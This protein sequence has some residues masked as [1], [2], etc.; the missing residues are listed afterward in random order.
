MILLVVIA[1][2][3][4]FFVTM[5]CVSVGFAWDESRRRKRFSQM[6]H[7]VEAG[8]AAPSKE[9]LRA[10]SAQSPARAWLLGLRPLK[11]LDRSLRQAG[12]DWSVER[13]IG[14]CAAG[15][16]AG[17]I[18]GYKVAL[19]SL[20]VLSLCLFCI[21]GTLTPVVLLR[22]RHGKNIKKFEEQFPEALD[23]LARCL[24]AGH[25]FNT[26]LEMLAAEAPDPLGSA[27]RRIANELQLGSPLDV[28]LNSLAE[29]VPLI[30]V[31]FFISAIMIQRETGGNLGEILNNLATL[32][33]SR[34][35]LRGQVKAMSAHGRITGLVLLLIPVVVLVILS[36]MSPDY[37]AGLTKDKT[38]RLLLIGAGCG[39]VLAYFCIRKIVNIKI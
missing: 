21:A 1:F 16:I 18:I 28:A 13:F 35:R 34:F 7:T 30:D 32:I 2:L 19:L 24:R 36:V 37:F 9:L 4:V 12:T 22:H 5:F 14:M 8:T 39:Q 26:G 3:I 38:G 11:S 6:L 10:V 23:F 29:S 31:R 25:G 27:V 33:R 15:A 20:P 17:A